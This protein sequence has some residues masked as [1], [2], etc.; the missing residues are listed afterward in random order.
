MTTTTS[1][2][3]AAAG[4]GQ[5]PRR[6]RRRT[7]SLQRKQSPLERV[8]APVLIGVTIVALIGIWEFVTK[9]GIVSQFVLPTPGDTF[10]AL[11]DVMRSLVTGGP[12]WDNFLVTAQ[13][14]LAGLLI[15]TIVGVGFGVLIAE[16]V[17]GRKVVQ[18]LMVALYAAPKVALAPLFVAWFG[19]GLTPKVVMAATIAF[20]PIMVD[21]AAGLSGVDEDQDKLF[22]M[23]RAS[24][25]QRLLKL[26]LPNS[27]PF[28]FAGLKSAAVLA[29]IGSIVAEFLGG[30]EGLGAMVK[31]ASVGFALDR[32]FALIFLLST[33]AFAIYLAVDLVERKVVHWR[34][35]GFV[36][37]DS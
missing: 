10:R 21:M 36:P 31:I 6:R 33:M 30:G 16:T 2:P 28:L 23:S 8:P 26:K 14:T 7:G 9:Q 3:Q 32:V 4:G 12:V 17:F 18:P 20:F 27:L 1:T 29:I 25:W 34:S 24:K 22:M 13:E 37:A 5:P 11:G 35:H 19:F 15:A